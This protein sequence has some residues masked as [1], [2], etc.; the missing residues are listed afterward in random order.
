M[1]N[2][3]MI[4]IVSAFRKI[5]SPIFFWWIQKTKYK[6]V[7]VKPIWKEIKGYLPQ[8]FSDYINQFRYFSDSWNGR[9]DN[10]IQHPDFFFTRRNS[11]RDCTDWTRIWFLYLKEQTYYNYTEI[12]EVFIIDEDNIN[13]AHMTCIAKNVKGDYRLFD[14]EYSETIY[15]SF[16]ACIDELHD[17][18]QH[19]GKTIYTIYSKG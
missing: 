1:I 16:D 8:E 3:T 17:R 7:E 15:D 14:Y 5:T 9:L 13:S 4:Q 19:K 6:D 2:K 18:Y 12:Y 11:D 10:T